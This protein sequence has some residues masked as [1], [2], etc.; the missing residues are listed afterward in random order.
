MTARITLP[1]SVRVKTSFAPL[2][3]GQ[4]QGQKSHLSLKM[5]KLCKPKVKYSDLLADSE[6]K[7]T[8]M[9]GLQS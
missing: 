8:N 6:P 3:Q 2:I 7:K 4:T 1:S 9:L 5:R